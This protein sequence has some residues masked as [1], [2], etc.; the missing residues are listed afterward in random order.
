M[1]LRIN[2]SIQLLISSKI[3]N[4]MVK[5]ISLYRT[6]TSS[7]ILIFIHVNKSR[8]RWKITISNIIMSKCNFR[9]RMSKSS[10]TT[11]WRLR[12]INM[13]LGC[14]GFCN[15]LNIQTPQLSHFLITKTTRIKC[16]NK[17]LLIQRFILDQKGLNISCKERWLYKRYNRYTLIRRIIHFCRII[18]RI[19]NHRRSDKSRTQ[20][21]IIISKIS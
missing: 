8:I 4:R 7:K 21:L 10:T 5:T 17:V 15:L 20:L 9:D 19:I 2:Y 3:C 1:K 18:S 6:A 14:L 12:I 11:I 16:R 13:I